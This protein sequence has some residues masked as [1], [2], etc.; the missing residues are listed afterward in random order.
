MARITVPREGFDDDG[1]RTLGPENA[2][3][4]EILATHYARWWMAGVHV[5]KYGP[6]L[7][8]SIT[9]SMRGRGSLSRRIVL[10]FSGSV[11]PHHT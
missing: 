8:A 4:I 5:A 11:S 10:P 3:A 1:M 6:V 7:K 2:A 9:L